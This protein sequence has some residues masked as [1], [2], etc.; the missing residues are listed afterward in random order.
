MP[1]FG[2]SAS[3]PGT[4]EPSP[5][6]WIEHPVGWAK[7]PDPRTRPSSGEPDHQPTSESL[8]VLTMAKRKSTTEN[9]V[10]DK[11]LANH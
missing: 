3:V 10:T 6:G 1:H 11:E 2:S 8:E 4:S 5:L 7:S 9:Q